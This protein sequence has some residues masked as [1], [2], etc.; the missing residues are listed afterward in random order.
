MSCLTASTAS[1]ITACSPAPA[2]RPTSRRSAPCSAR[3]AP[4]RPPSRRPNPSRSPCA[5]LAPAAAAPCASSKSSGAARNP[6]HAPHPGIRQHED[7]PLPRT[8]AA[9]EPQQFPAR[10]AWG[11]RPPRPASCPKEPRPARRSRSPA[12]KN[13]QKWHTQSTV[14]EANTAPSRHRQRSF[15]IGITQPPAASS[16]GGF[17]TRVEVARVRGLPPRPASENLHRSRRIPARAKGA[18]PTSRLLTEAMRP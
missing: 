18:I 1:G 16:L 11:R 6:G 7:A 9:P 12:Q 14:H 13:R 5:S 2:A 17:P 15:S 4:P 3:R 8:I 10:P